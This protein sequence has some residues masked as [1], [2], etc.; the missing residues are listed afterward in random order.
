[1][2]TYVEDMLI[3]GETDAGCPSERFGAEERTAHDPLLLI[4]Q[5]I[6]PKPPLSALHRATGVGTFLYIYTF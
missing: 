2:M 3:V 1:M 4:D 5:E 6:R